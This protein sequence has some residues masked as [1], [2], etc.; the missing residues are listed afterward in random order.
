[1]AIFASA[2]AATV[3][4]QAALGRL[5]VVL[6]SYDQL[7]LH[8]NE[9][10]QKLAPHMVIFDEVRRIRVCMLL[11]LLNS[12]DQLQLH[13]NELAQRLAPHAVIFDEVRGCSLTTILSDRNNTR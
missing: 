4:Q 7:R 1:M 5:E 8:G 6:C 12:C 9:L 2:N 13:G 11:V 10:A 3:L